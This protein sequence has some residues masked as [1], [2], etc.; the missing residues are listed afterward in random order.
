MKKV[1]FLS[2]CFLFCYQYS[3]A[4]IFGQP[5]IACPEQT[6]TF[7]SPANTT[8]RHAWDFATGDLKG[9]PQANV[10]NSFMQFTWQ[11]ETVKIIKDDSDGNWY[12]FIVNWGY[13]NILR[14]NFGNSLDNIPTYT[15]VGT[16][17]CTTPSRPYHITFAKHNGSW[18]GF[19]TS[20]GGGVV[21]FKFG[22][23][24]SNLNPICQTIVVGGPGSAGCDVLFD[25]VTNKW[26]LIVPA[27]SQVTG[28]LVYDMGNDLDNNAILIR[29]IPN[30]GGF[31]NGFVKDQN[32]EWHAPLSLIGQRWGI[33]RFGN[34][35]NNIP[36]I[37][38]YNG[39]PNPV[40]PANPNS[41][42]FYYYKIVKDGMDWWAYAVEPGGSVLRWKYGKSLY[43]RPV[44][45]NLGNF[46]VVGGLGAPSLGFDIIKDD[47]TSAWYL[48]TINRN[49]NPY[50]STVANVAAFVRLKFPNSINSDVIISDNK[51]SVDVKFESGK[52]I[53][54][55]KTYNSDNRLINHY[56]DSINIKD[57]GVAKF[58]LQNQCLGLTTNF[59][60]LSYGNLNLVNQWIWDFGNGQTSSIPNPTYQYTQSGN[61]EVKLIVNNTNGCS[62]TYVKN[63]RVSKYP[64]ADFRIKQLDCN[65][66][67]IDLEDLSSISTSEVAQ[68]GRIVQ[69]IW[70][71]G[72]GT[73]WQA[74]P[75]NTTY[76]RKGNI[77][78]SS[79]DGVMPFL[80]NVTP[81]VGG[82][83]YTITLTVVDDAGCSA[84]TSKEIT[85]LNSDLP[86]VN[87]SSTP[88]CATVPTRFTDMSTLPT[89]T[90]GEINQ[91]K[92]IFKTDMG[93]KLDSTT[94]QNPFYTFLTAGTYQVELTAQNSNGCKRTLTKNIVVNNS[95]TS[96]FQT[97][98]N[99]GF[100]PLQVS[101]TNLTTNANSFYWDFGNGMISTQQ[102]PIMTFTTAGTYLIR[103]QARNAQG[104][105]TIA[106]K[107]IIVGNPPTA[108]EPFEMNGFKV[109]PNPFID[110]ITIEK[111]NSENAELIILDMFGREL[112][113]IWIENDLKTDIFLD[114][115]A[116][117]VYLLKIKQKGK[118][119]IQKIIKKGN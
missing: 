98:T 95:L 18:Y 70:S 110:K 69:R 56:A 10:I 13:G 54:E 19:T 5:N 41:F 57:A 23:S 104:C 30:T 50:T 91:W 1:I 34:S 11:P 86:T 48:F 75:L 102:N 87:F 76:I 28:M 116:N 63:I 62:S 100:A 44:Y 53:M 79:I 46:G 42:A 12:G 107:N 7:T 17:G 114:N 65:S 93:I 36:T 58:N 90:N 108:L 61:Y 84:S 66:G 92:W 40:P 67:T 25:D 72:D 51:P 106:T 45:Q 43:N 24:L 81:L 80:A 37:E 94:L 119:F 2:I 26:F 85:L 14:A 113:Q 117:G 6:I 29:T 96:Q 105:G 16:Y 21:R 82:R 118:E 55:L 32:G 33:A 115:I 22:T 39:I 101:F 3:K 8:L 97:S 27:S 88:A 9:I 73:Y 112:K 109:S 31:T 15:Q 103:Y 68:G 38:Y 74:S 20:S 83:K 60:N 4:Q 78:L 64:K 35:L 89:N 49:F 99:G 77:S 59:I 111:N 71:F 52:N 47:A